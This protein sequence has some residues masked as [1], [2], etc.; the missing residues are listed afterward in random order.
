MDF[1]SCSF[2][3]LLKWIFILISYFF[4]WLDR[5]SWFLLIA[6]LQPPYYEIELSEFQVFSRFLG[7]SQDDASLAHAALRTLERE[8]PRLRLP[9]CEIAID[10]GDV[11]GIAEGNV[12]ERVREKL[13]LP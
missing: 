9:R 6:D 2:S 5:P 8:E 13:N 10:E 12:F 4:V 3:L 7:G 1:S 11:S